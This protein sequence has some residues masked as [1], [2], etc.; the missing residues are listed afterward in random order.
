M[1]GNYFYPLNFAG[2]SK[3][4]ADYDK[5]YFTIIPVP[6]DSATS[7]NPGARRGPLAIID[8]SLQLEWFDDELEIDSYKLGIHTLDFLDTKIHPE[9][10]IDILSRIVEKII[11]DGKFPI[12]L[13][14][15]H[16]LSYAPI[17]T[18]KE[19]I[20]E[21][22]VIH[23]D[24]HSDLREEYQGSP[25]SHACTARRILDLGLPIVQIGIR[26][27][28]REDYEFIKN[29]PQKIKTFFAREIYKKEDYTFLQKFVKTDKIYITFD[30]DVFDPS[31]IPSTGTPEP[32]GLS[33]YQILEIMKMFI[34]NKELIG[35]DVVELAPNI[36]GHSEFIIAKLIYKIIGYITY[37]KERR[38]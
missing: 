21:F 12:V 17:K 13:G 22:T 20:S 2:L 3:E 38:R 25:H 33:W 29:N 5:S 26:S 24:A 16:S 35:F 7:Y 1:F 30:V 10:T 11:S 6:Y 4:Y 28:T 15:D 8:S 19:K 31:L 37:K 36:P 9:K 34:E 32:G 14:G 27:L 18:F 23:F